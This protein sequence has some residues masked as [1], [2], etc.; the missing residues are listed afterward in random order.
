MIRRNGWPRSVPR[1]TCLA[2]S[3][4][5]GGKRATC[6]PGF[7]KYLEGAEVTGG[8][9]ERDGHII[10][11]RG[12]GTASDFALELVEVLEGRRTKAVDVRDGLAG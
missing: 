6:Y 10:T 7:E 8:R 5:F 12:P 9:V 2:V 11:G 1:L 3:G 4:C